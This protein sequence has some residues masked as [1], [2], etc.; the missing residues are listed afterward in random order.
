[1]LKYAEYVG[2]KTCPKENIFKFRN[3]LPD[4]YILNL[5][6][7]SKISKKSF[8]RLK[9]TKSKQNTCKLLVPQPSTVTVPPVTA[10]PAR[11]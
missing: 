2:K 5:L 10:A 3:S 8:E 6:S 7:V 4:K 9:T 11:K 1:M